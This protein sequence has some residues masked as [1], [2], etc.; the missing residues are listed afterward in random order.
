MLACHRAGAFQIFV[1][2]LGRDAERLDV[3]IK[4]GATRAIDVDQEDVVEVVHDEA[5]GGSVDL[6]IDVSGGG[7]STFMTALR[8]VR[9]GGTVIIASGSPKSP[10][11]LSLLDLSLLRKKRI[12]S[13]RRSKRKSAW[14]TVA[15]WRVMGP[16]NTVNA[17]G[18]PLSD[19]RRSP[20]KRCGWSSLAMKSMR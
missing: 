13:L 9:V 15:P 16:R 8:S 12:K 14:P 2:G 6:V 3:A 18:S 5:R 19:S 20:S 17:A 11:D 7:I 10:G 4:L 1:S